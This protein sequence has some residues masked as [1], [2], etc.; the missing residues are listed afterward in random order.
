VGD[1][2]KAAV[3]DIDENK[4]KVTLSVREYLSHLEEKEITKYLDN[5]GTK[6]ASVT[7]GD[8]IDKSKIGK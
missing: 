8:L 7:L 2:I 6:T 5:D 3:I 4:K 1:E